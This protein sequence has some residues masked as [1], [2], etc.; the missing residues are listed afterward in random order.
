MYYATNE[1]GNRIYIDDAIRKEKYYCPFCNSRMIMKCG[2]IVCH[3]FA[4]KANRTCDPWYNGNSK[5]KWHRYMQSMFSPENQ[6]VI[7]WNEDHSIFH[8]ADV[9][10]T[11][12]SSTKK[13][14]YEFQHSS[15]SAD[16]FIERSLYYLDLGYTLIWVFDYCTLQSPKV[17]FR[18]EGTYQ[19]DIH[20]NL[21]K[22]V[23]PGKDR[24]RLF[25]SDDMRDFLN[26]TNCNENGNLFAFFFV[27]TGLGEEKQIT[28]GDTWSH[29]KWEYKNPF[30]LEEKYLKIHFSYS[31]DLSDF[32]ATTWDKQ[33]FE[34]YLVQN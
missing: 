33:V 27:R 15:I 8:I 31:D 9:V 24:V 34:E 10:K 2:Q 20:K 23:W 29:I 32:Y 1:E 6:E 22:Y 21:H 5:S 13:Y 12:K 28:Y 11:N 7:I 25:D 17:I 19:S 3:H 30:Q 26:E 4:H 18:A 16:A 14:V